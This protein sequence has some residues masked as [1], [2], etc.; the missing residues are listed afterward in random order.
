MSSYFLRYSSRVYLHGAVQIDVANAK[1]AVAAAY[2]LVV[3]ACHYGDVN[4]HLDGKLDGVSV[5]DVDG[6]DGLSLGV[7]LDSG[8]RQH[9]VDIEN[10][11]AY[12]R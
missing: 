6:P 12:L 2:V 8:A 1:I 10:D 4:A 7:H 3:A 11:G 9:S 5:L